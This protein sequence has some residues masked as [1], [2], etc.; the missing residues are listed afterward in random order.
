MFTIEVDEG[1]R[2]S[3]LHKLKADRIGA[4]VHFDPPVHLQP[5]YRHLEVGPGSL[6]QAEA[7]ECDLA[8]VPMHPRLTLEQLYEVLTA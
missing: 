6:P 8:G 2:N 4:S 5:V 3:V 1:R 7:L